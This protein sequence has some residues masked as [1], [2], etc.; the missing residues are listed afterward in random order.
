M[1]PVKSGKIYTPGTTFPLFLFM[2][3][4]T[5]TFKL[6]THSLFGRE[7][8]LR[9]KRQNRGTRTIGGGLENKLQ[10]KINEGRP[11]WFSD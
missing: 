8:A 1:K 4:F 5:N 7:F 9:K 6:N 2:L 11:W 10:E 3:I